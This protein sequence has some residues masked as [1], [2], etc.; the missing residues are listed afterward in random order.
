VTGPESSEPPDDGSGEPPR[1]DP[2]GWPDTPAD[3]AA[4]RTAPQRTEPLVYVEPRT[5]PATAP[6]TPPKA[7]RPPG[8][9]VSPPSGDRLPPYGARPTGWT[10]GSPTAL[11]SHLTSRAVVPGTVGQPNARPE[12][13]PDAQRPDIPQRPPVPTGVPPRPQPLP[14]PRPT[15]PDQAGTE[16]HTDARTG[17][18]RDAPTQAIPRGGAATTVVPG[19]HPGQRASPRPPLT[20][21][22]VRSAKGRKA[23][24]ALRRLDPWSVF[25]MTL[26]LSLFLAVV[27]IVASVVLYAVLDRLGIPQSINKTQSE[28]QGGNGVL[29]QGRFVGGAALLAALNVVLLTALATLGSLL[30]NLCASFTGGLELTLAERD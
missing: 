27:T 30:Y 16:A 25:V 19:K 3:E 20:P 4:E 24:L 15:S 12:A 29:T 22:T 7:T 13:P 26:L 17:A 14:P 2:T 28:I 1:P 5:T 8:P 10:G 23:K 9:P 21:G 18:F 6:A 11:P